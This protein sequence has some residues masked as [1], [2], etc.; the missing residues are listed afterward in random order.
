[1]T[2]RVH[3]II[4]DHAREGAVLRTAFFADHAAQVDQVARAMAPSLAAGGK[5]LAQGS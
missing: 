4:T 2:E 1:M 5:I 3:K